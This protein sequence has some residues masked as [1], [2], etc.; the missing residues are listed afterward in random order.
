MTWYCGT[1]EV[2]V[3]TSS[4]SAVDGT[5]QLRA[6]PAIILQERAPSQVPVTWDSLLRSLYGNSASVKVV[7]AMSLSQYNA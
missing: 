6:P 4:M 1:Q 5:G 3:F 7:L 2:K